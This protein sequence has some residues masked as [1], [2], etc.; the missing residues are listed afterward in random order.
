MAR[1]NIRQSRVEETK[2]EARYETYTPP[3]T[4]D[5]PEEVKQSFIDRGLHWRWVRVLSDN[6]DDYK[7]VAMRRREGY[8]PVSIQELPAHCRDLFETKSFGQ[9]AGK[10][11]DIVMV[12]DIALFKIPKTK[13]EARTRYYEQLAVNNEIAQRKQLGQDSK[14]NKLLPIYDESKTVVR[15]G[16]RSKESPQEFGQTLKS[17]QTN[18]DDDLADMDE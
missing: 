10:Y 1:S 11:S 18:D 4:F 7:N 17:T 9:A 15:L 6:A 5:L 3:S 12:G 8:E 16:N 13:A 14:M 2:Q